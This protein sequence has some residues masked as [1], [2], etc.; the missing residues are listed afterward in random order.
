MAPLLSDFAKNVYCECLLTLKSL[1]MLCIPICQTIEI[2]DL[3]GCGHAVFIMTELPHSLDQHETWA[4]GQRWT[5]H[6]PKP[7]L[8]SCGLVPEQHWLDVKQSQPLWYS[9]DVQSLNKSAYNITIIHTSFWLYK[10]E[11][12]LAT[13]C[14]NLFQPVWMLINKSFNH[15]EKRWVHRALLLRCHNWLLLLFSKLV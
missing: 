3:K 13:S 5:Q 11:T 1:K 9:S 14:R 10:E 4:T 8:I 15:W 6:S 7:L 12:T 2:V